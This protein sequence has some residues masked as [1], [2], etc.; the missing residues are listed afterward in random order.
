[1]I[2]G[3]NHVQIT[4]P[5]GAEEEGK[6]FYCGVLGLPEIEKP[7][8]L[9][10]RGG[11]WLKV[12]DKDVHVGTEDGFDRTKTKSHI[13]YQVRDITYWRKIIENNH[14]KIV[15]SVPI[16]HFERFEFRDPFG[17]RVEMIQKV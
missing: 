13:A 12:G 9:K 16:P 10:D 8:I 2:I 15:D 4:I 17:N 14:I 11:F 7:E 5:N 3:L 6:Q 1:M